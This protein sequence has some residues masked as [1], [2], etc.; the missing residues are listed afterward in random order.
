MAASEAAALNPQR[1]PNQTDLFAQK[2]PDASLETNLLKLPRTNEE[3]LDLP[4]FLKLKQ[5]R[6]K[7]TKRGAFQSVKVKS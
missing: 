4:F 6:L 5:E 3:M 2:S 1:S 7:Q